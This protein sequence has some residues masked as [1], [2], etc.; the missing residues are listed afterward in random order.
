MLT[1]LNGPGAPTGF[2]DGV[3]RRGFLTIGGAAMGGLALNQILQREASAGIIN[4]H[5]AII[6]I[7]SSAE[8]V[9]EFR[10]G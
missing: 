5:K 6:N 2:C 4:S 3:S 10:L 1:I 7:A 9:G 8:F